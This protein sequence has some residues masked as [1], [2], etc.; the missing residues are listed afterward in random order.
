MWG[1]MQS[2]NV[3]IMM[4]LILVMTA[5]GSHS[6]ESFGEVNG[7]TVTRVEK[8]NDPLDLAAEAIRGDKADQ[9]TELFAQGVS[10]D[11]ELKNGRTLLIEAVTWGRAEIVSL[12]L[13]KGARTDLKDREGMTAFD[14]A[15]DRPALLRLLSP[16]TEL[17]REKIFAAV[18]GDDFNEVKQL[19]R[20][21]VDP[22]V[23]SDTGETPLTLAVI[24]KLEKVVRVLLQESKTDVN[25]KNKSGQSPLGLAR[26]VGSVSI[27]K[28]LKRRGA[29]E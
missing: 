27:E 9:L 17:E 1:L 2:S 6:T 22:N 21:G 4:I 25:L 13:Q 26:E 5:C 16:Q 7:G 14:H 23:F 10:V 12:L 8:S 24:K 19:L 18:E 11:A 28:L 29:K 15:K 3:F 20:Q